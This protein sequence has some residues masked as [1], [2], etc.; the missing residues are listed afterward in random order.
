MEVKSPVKDMCIKDETEAIQA[1][2]EDCIESGNYCF[3]EWPEK[4]P[5]LLPPDH[6]HISFEIINKNERRI[7]AV[8]N[9]A[10]L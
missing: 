2:C 9:Q 3:I 6:L 10:T 5:E 1:G 8:V 4:A 7:N